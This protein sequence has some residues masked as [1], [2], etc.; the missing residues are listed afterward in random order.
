MKFHKK[1]ALLIL[2]SMIGAF[3]ILRVALNF[4]PDS[5]FNVGS[6]NI[7]HLFTGLLFI[8]FCGIPLTIFHKTSKLMDVMA[9]GFGAGLGMALDEWVYLI[10]TDG[11]NASYLLPVSFWGGVVMVGITSLYIIILLRS[12]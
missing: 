9:I 1:R 5:D 6:Y 8:T 3:I 11:S 10:A 12:E 4:S 2:G 7:H